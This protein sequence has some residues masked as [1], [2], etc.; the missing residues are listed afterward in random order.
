MRSSSTSKYRLEEIVWL[1]TLVINQ[2][3]LIYSLK[4]KENPKSLLVEEVELLA[5]PLELAA[6]KNAI[7]E[8]MFKGT[9]RNI[10]GE[11]SAD[12]SKNAEVG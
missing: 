9:M 5:S 2:S 7:T 12:N 10:A 3:I 1:I 11:E 4:N 6:Y 8:E